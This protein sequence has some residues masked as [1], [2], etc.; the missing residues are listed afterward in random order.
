M[1]S[2]L[3]QNV[4]FSKLNTITKYHL[5]YESLEHKTFFPGQLIMSLHQRSPLCVEYRDFFKD[6]TSKFRREIDQK[7]S[8]TAFDEKDA[9][10]KTSIYTEYFGKLN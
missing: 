8:K 1:L 6:G 7:S 3:E 9:G 10:K 5:V 4:Y 2:K